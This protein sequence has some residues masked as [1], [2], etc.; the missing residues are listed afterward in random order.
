MKMKPAPFLAAIGA[1][2]IGQAA[3]QQGMIFPKWN[4]D[5]NTQQQ[6]D[7]SGL[8]P[9]QLLAS[10]TG[11][12]ELVAGIL[13][14]QADSYF[15]NGNYDAVL[16]LV[17]L[18]TL[19][20]P[21]QIDVYATGTWHMAYNFTDEESRSDRRYI[22][23]A[24]ALV[25][26]GARNNSET[27]ELFFET[28]W[29]WYHKIDDDYGQAVKEMETANSKKDMIPARRNLL[30]VIYQRDGQVDQAR[31]YL[32][33]LLDRATKDMK[34]RPHDIMARSNR[35]TIEANLDSLVMRMT[36][37]GYFAQQRKDGTFESG[38]YDTR[39]PFDVNFGAKV[40]VV[41]NKV[42][43]VEGNWG[44]QSVGT[45]VRIVLKDSDY[46]NS[47]PGG[48]DWDA[49]TAVQLDPPKGITFMQ[50]QLFVRDQRFNRKIDMSRDPR[51]Y[52]F[53]KKNY[54]IE[55]YYNPRSGAH[56]MQ[57]RFGWSGEGMTDKRFLNEEIREGQR[58]IFARLEISK[59]Q[60]TRTGEWSRKTPVLRTPG[61]QDRGAAVGDGAIIKLPGLAGD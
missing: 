51:M 11:F 19:L 9:D 29:L 27:Y 53:A 23:S 8:S 61:Y 50:D 33:S 59:D 42:L 39:P 40:S 48:M 52:P 46:P 49:G 43:Q 54:V 30:N 12:R 37:R 47:V 21:K 10:L 20:D 31:K 44:V 57:D 18:V 16:P 41:S 3:L 13:W 34:D 60:I 32:H 2:A 5:Y 6:G 24:L 35:D 45:R 7:Y 38:S 58:V 14:V 36:Q 15:D 25:K 56:H 17:R 28:G 26:E 1:L 22:P 55:F 4:K